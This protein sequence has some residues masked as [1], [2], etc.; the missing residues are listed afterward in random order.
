M[1]LGLYGLVAILHLLLLVGLYWANYLTYLNLG[2]LV[3]KMLYD[4]VVKIRGNDC[5]ILII[6]PGTQKNSLPFPPVP[7]MSTWPSLL[8]MWI[9]CRENVASDPP[10]SSASVS[11]LGVF[12]KHMRKPVSR[13]HSCS[14]A[15][16]LLNSNILVS[17]Q[18]KPPGS[19]FTP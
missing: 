3:Y 11:I 6:V 4:T 8:L 14:H 10:S 17:S 1:Q 15:W 2:F 12:N 16:G 18:R 19:A 9:V 13:T 7:L 5:K